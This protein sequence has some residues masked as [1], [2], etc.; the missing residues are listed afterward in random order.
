M[1]D[2]VVFRSAFRH[3]KKASF[4]GKSIK[5]PDAD[6]MD[7]MR[8]DIALGHDSVDSDF[9]MQG[10][11]KMMVGSGSSGSQQDSDDDLGIP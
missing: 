9:H 4:K 6:A 5:N 7:K 2:K 1:S 8:R 11:A 3:S 10:M